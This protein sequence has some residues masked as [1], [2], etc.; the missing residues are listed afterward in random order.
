[1]TKIE[2]SRLLGI[3]RSAGPAKAEQAFLKKHD[4][5]RRKLCRG[6]I[7]ADR[8]KAQSEIA[9]IM[10]ARQTLQATATTKSPARK[11]VP[12]KTTTAKP[13]TTRPTRTG[14]RPKPARA[15]PATTNNYQKPQTLADA[16]E[17]FDQ[18]SL[19]P[20]RVIIAALILT[21]IIVLIELLTNL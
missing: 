10:T 21:V 15:R 13:T 8:Q 2:A 16:W 4:E 6:N 5:L 18:L 19:L 7:K 17:M 14:A 11:P 20:A 3:S 9:I 12:R 1:M